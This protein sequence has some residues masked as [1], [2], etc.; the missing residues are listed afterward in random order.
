MP[1]KSMVNSL[2]SSVPMSEKII[3]KGVMKHLQDQ[4]D[5]EIIIDKRN[6]TTEEKIYSRILRRRE[7]ERMQIIEDEDKNLTSVVAGKTFLNYADTFDDYQGM[8]PINKIK[9]LPPN[10]LQGQ[11]HSYKPRV[12]GDKI[13]LGA[14]IVEDNIDEVTLIPSSASLND[15]DFLPTKRLSYS[16][17]ETKE[18]SSEKV[19]QYLN[20]QHEKFDNLVNRNLQKVLKES[21]EIEPPS[22]RDS[23]YDL[24]DVRDRNLTHKL[25]D[26]SSIVE[27][28]SN[29][30]LQNSPW[31]SSSNNSRENS[32]PGTPML[33]NNRVATFEL[34]HGDND[35]VYSTQEELEDLIKLLDNRKKG[36]LLRL[37][38]DELDIFEDARDDINE[39][40]ISLE[41]MQQEDLNNLQESGITIDKVQALAILLIRLSFTAIKLGIPISLWLYRKYTAN[42]LYMIN[43]KNFNKLL[44]FLIKLLKSLD[45]KINSDPFSSY[46]YGHGP[47]TK[48]PEQEQQQ[49]DQNFDELYNEMTNNATEFLNTKLNSQGVSNTTT[50]Q[51]LAA[52]YLLSRYIPQLLN[53]STVARRRRH[54]NVIRK[55]DPKYSQ[56]FSKGKESSSDLPSDSSSTS[57][58]PS[59]IEQSSSEENLNLLHAAETFAA[60]F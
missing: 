23:I 51:G 31:R 1:L 60:E 32:I 21:E 4:P 34:E 11:N 36:Q 56:Y 55:N 14:T 19:K 12:S 46:Q 48:L 43:K 40:E 25:Q 49:N 26:I 2:V 6:T 50:W 58:S 16:T 37:L 24:L 3:P 59:K 52:N 20:E 45:G 54:E 5:D 17:Y 10:K 29:K 22:M 7:V 15:S 47:S 41:K 28:A 39:E 30:V 33:Q 42:E 9:T 35:D 27:V 8:Q 57:L 44:G 38:Q 18:V 53:E 13:L